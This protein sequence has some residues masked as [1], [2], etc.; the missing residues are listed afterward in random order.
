MVHN[1]IACAEGEVVTHGSHSLLPV[2]IFVR[3]DSIDGSHPFLNI[4]LGEH[5]REREREREGEGEGG[6]ERKRERE[7]MSYS[8]RRLHSTYQWDG[9]LSMKILGQ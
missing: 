4:V 8:I 6:G 3:Q 9:M 5:L 1:N 7:S 2:N